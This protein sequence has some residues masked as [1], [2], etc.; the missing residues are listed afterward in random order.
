MHSYMHVIQ[1]YNHG[2]I[3]PLS[4]VYDYTSKPVKIMGFSEDLEK[5]DL[6]TDHVKEEGGDYDIPKTTI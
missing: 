6:T 4:D 3:Q 1:G 2:H 5:T